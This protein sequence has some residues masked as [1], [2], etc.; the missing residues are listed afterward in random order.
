MARWRCAAWEAHCDA[1]RQVPCGHHGQAGQDQDY[2]QGVSPRL[3][4]L[5]RA[6]CD[7]EF[8]VTSTR[9]VCATTSGRS[10]S[11]TPLSRWSR[12]KWSRRPRSRSWRVRTATLSS[13]GR[14]NPSADDASDD[15]TQG[16]GFGVSLSLPAGPTSSRVQYPLSRCQ[17]VLFCNKS[18]ASSSLVLIQQ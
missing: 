17:E 10:S 11:R 3:L 15:G 8:R 7:P 5:K 18:K 9:T 16:V 1:V 12:T 2:A 6:L 4:N 13:L 14:N